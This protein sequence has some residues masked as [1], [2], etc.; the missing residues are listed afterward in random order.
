[1]EEKLDLLI[2]AGV[3]K[4]VSASINVGPSSPDQVIDASGQWVVPGLID[5]HVHL[6]EPGQEWKETVA[7]GAAAAV[8]GG[9]TAVCCMPNTDPVN[10]SAEVTEFILERADTAGLC[11]VYPIGAVTMGSKGERLA[12]LSELK[13]AGCVAFSDD[14]QPVY[15][16]EIMRRALEW[17]RMFNAPISCHEEDKHL[18]RGG[19]M[20]ESSLSERMG[21]IGMPK[22]AEDVM[23][24]R[25]IELARVT[26]GHVHICHISSARGVELVR[27]AKNDGINVTAEVTPHHLVLTEEA[28]EGYDTN[29]KMS[30]PLREEEERLALIEGLS[31][32]TIDV[33]ASDHAPHEAASKEVEFSEA[34]Y[35]IL[36]LQ[37]S[38][39]LLLDFVDSGTISRL[40]M[41]EVLSTAPAKVFNL[42]GGSLKEGKVADLTI[43]DPQVEW[44]FSPETVKSLSFNSPFIGRRMKGA[45]RATIVDGRLVMLDGQLIRSA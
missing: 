19:A 29:A 39:P 1:M 32:G 43:I 14:G 41:I 25:D 20:N 12:P 6:R 13:K 26:G 15:N 21:L 24:A 40:R 2:E 5:L 30:P 38:L 4:E 34:A 27:R 3:V 8:M 31:D 10:D 45:A 9:F 22:V 18:S 42:K 28:V 7:S 33:V 37:T 44:I 17:V 11:R 36:G 16:P 23:I 35:G